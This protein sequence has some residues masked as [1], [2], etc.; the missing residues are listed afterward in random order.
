MKKVL[1]AIL[2]L[3]LISCSKISKSDL[4][5]VW[6]VDSIKQQEI[7]ANTDSGWYSGMAIAPIF[8]VGE[9]LTI[10]KSNII[11]CPTTASMVKCYDDYPG[12]INYSLAGNKLVI[13]EQH[14]SYY[15]IDGNGDVSAGEIN[16][17]AMEF[18]VGIAGNEMDLIGK[19]EETDNLGNVKKRVNVMI[20]LSRTK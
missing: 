10:S 11:P 1:F 17:R 16:F 8:F 12:Y 7:T 3:V 20:D 19:F 18:E 2:A 6:T 15:R 5:G 9:T 14:Y 13:P 4:R